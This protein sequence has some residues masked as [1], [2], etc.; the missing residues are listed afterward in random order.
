MVPED[1]VLGDAS[2]T[3]HRV[4]VPAYAKIEDDCLR[5]EWDSPSDPTQRQRDADP[6]GAL[7][8]FLRIR[9][10]RGVL[11]FARRYGPLGICEHGLPASH[12]PPPPAAIH[13]RTVWW[14]SPL[15]RDPL[16]RWYYFAGLA[17]AVIAIA[18]DLRQN[19]PGSVADWRT[20][21]AEAPGPDYVDGAD[22]WRA[23]LVEHLA[24]S[25]EAGRRCLS[26][27]L[28]GWLDLGNVRPALDWPVANAAPSLSLIG[29]TFGVLGVQLLFAVAA[30]HSLAICSGCST[31]YLRKSKPR[32]DRRNFCAM[33]GATVASRLRQRDYRAR[34]RG[35]S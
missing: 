10:A 32:S 31:P 5:W 9:D 34:M 2:L 35:G 6:K 3:R 30:A 26:D 20:I 11:R 8:A 4:L 19:K 7:D 25:V 17:R 12:N 27:V 33:C 22:D 23:S 15:G 14:C 29:N 18:A 1:G 13:S 21:F 16:D 24:S 28:L